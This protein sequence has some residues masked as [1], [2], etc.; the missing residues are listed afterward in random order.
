MSQ[1]I[2]CKNCKHGSAKCQGY[3]AHPNEYKNDYYEENGDFSGA[4]MA[5]KNEKNNCPD[6]EPCETSRFNKWLNKYL[7]LK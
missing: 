7:G 3:C 2:F 4:R 6:Y 5:V 1:L